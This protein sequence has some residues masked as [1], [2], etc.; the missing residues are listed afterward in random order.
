MIHIVLGLAVNCSWLIK[1]LD[2]N[3]AFLLGT[4][5]DEVYMSQPPDF[6]DRD[7]PD[8]VCRLRKAIYGLKQ[9]LRTW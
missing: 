2:V 7:R 4:L 6:I 8:Y 3:N 5:T 1:K 9:A